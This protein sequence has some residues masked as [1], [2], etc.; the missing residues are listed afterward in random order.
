MF[1]RLVGL[2]GVGGLMIVHE[3]ITF[4]AECAIDVF[5]IYT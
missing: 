4:G 1:G 5:A 2:F 3:F